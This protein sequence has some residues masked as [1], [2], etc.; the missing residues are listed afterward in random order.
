VLQENIARVLQVQEN[1]RRVACQS[2]CIRSRDAENE[3]CRTN[4]SWSKVG[5][6]KFTA[7][8]PEINFNDVRPCVERRPNLAQVITRIVSDRQREI[9]PFAWALLGTRKR[10]ELPTPNQECGEKPSP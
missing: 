4:G 10:R 9:A 5:S 2:Q 6:P 3:G 7:E 8:H 1:P